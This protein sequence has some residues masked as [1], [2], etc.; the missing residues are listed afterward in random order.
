MAICLLAEREV[1]QLICGNRREIFVCSPLRMLPRLISGQDNLTH[2]RHRQI[3]YTF[4][5]M[6]ELCGDAL[7]D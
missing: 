2:Q 6:R 5:E 1:E 4:V 7:T 3:V